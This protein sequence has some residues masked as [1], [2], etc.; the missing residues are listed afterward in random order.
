MG[1]KSKCGCKLKEKSYYELKVPAGTYTT[2]NIFRLM[3]E[4]FS[5]RCWH[6]WKHKRWMD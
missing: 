5:H 2:D 1:C 3:W 6:L 4:V